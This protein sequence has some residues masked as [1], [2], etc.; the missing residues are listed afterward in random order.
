MINPELSALLKQ[1]LHNIQR[2]SVIVDD[3][4]QFVDRYLAL[5]DHP[6]SEQVAWIDAFSNG[7]LNSKMWLIDQLGRFD[8]NLGKVWIMCGWIGTLA[9]L[10][11]RRQ[12]D[13]KFDSIHSF[14]IDPGCAELADTMNRPD[15]TDG[16]RFKASTL[17]VNLLEYHDFWWTTKKYNGEDELI[18][19]STDTII[20]TS[21]EHLD[22]F[23]AWYSKIPAGKFV[24]MQCS[25]HD[26]HAGHVN[27]MNSMF[28]LSARA[29]CSRVY[30]KGVLD[31][32][33]YERYMLIGR[34]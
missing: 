20:N 21:C 32:G 5:V 22:D 1:H 12:N 7:Q 13:L 3:S 26:D 4:D 34:R 24:V 27:S 9:Y 33:T 18:C 14:D 25:N 23:D 10:M 28:E 15:V 6:N 31:C 19:D 29:R 17:D 8:L 16:W 30:Y 11:L 2:T